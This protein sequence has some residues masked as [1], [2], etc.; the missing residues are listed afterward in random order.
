MSKI[1]WQSVKNKPSMEMVGE[2]E[3]YFGI[4]FPKDYIEC[5]LAND[6]GH[7]SRN[8]F[9]VNDKEESINNLLTVTDNKYSG[10]INV[11]QQ[12]SD[13]LEDKIIPF[14]RD[15]G[16]NLICFDYRNNMPPSVV[17]WDHEKAFLETDNAIVK[18]ADTFTQFL[19][20]L[21]ELE[22]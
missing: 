3:K 12:V 5:I 1:N 4:K 20:N 11:A 16:G 18:I 22:E 7:P 21:Q 17:F 9:F 14:G 2:I 8:V 13:R 15:A 19:N 10:I 6:G